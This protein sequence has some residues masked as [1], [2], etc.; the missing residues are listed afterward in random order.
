M[1]IEETFLDII[2]TIREEL[3]KY[4]QREKILREALEQY[5]DELNG[6]PAL[7]AQEALAKVEEMK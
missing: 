5:A 1:T 3:D 4:K 6:Q 7:S 2:R